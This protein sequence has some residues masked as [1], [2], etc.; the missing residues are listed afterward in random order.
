MALIV[1]PAIVLSTIRYSESS[2]IVRLATRDLG[3]QSA[4]AKGALRP[5]SR[6]GAALQVLSA[7]QAQLHVKEN[8]E[9]H[10]LGAFDLTR[11]PVALAADLDRYAAASV[12]AEI[13]LRFAPPDPH[14][15]SYEL[16]AASLDELEQAPASTAGALGLRRIW[17][18]VSVLGFAPSLDA[19]VHDGAPVAP[20][21]ELAF[22]TRDGG[23]V[24][25]ACAGPSGATRLPPDARAALAALLHP[26]APLPALD[27]RHA[28]AHRRLLSRYVRYHLAEGGELPALEFWTRRRWVAA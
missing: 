4:I 6:F 23:A 21:G 2:K 16:L 17:H 19:C 28:A 20:G 22:S 12:L 18:L 7:G 24:C 9:L 15:A 11:V 26:D 14:P 1:T 25:A 27:P 10:T 8:R 5:R 3:V 13:M